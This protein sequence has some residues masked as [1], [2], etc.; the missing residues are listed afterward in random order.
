MKYQNQ[1]ILL[2]HLKKGEEK[3]Y[4]YLV[5]TYNKRLFGYALTL[6]RNEEIAQDIIQ[7]VFL[8]TWE[9]R[10]KIHITSS[11]QNYLFRSVHNEFITLYNKKRST[12]LL[13]QKY[14]ESL[15]RVTKG[16]D[17]DFL[18]KALERITIEIENLPFKCK[19][20]FLLSRKEGLTNIEIADYLNI[21]IKTVEAHITKAF[22]VLRKNLKDKLN[23]ILFI[24]FGFQ[25]T[26]KIY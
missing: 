18:I 25:K 1:S 16:Y 10:K 11:L 20:V 8:K 3:A 5:D 15:E 21:S 9:K 22:T 26:Q 14:F 2:K 24:L 7:N 6:C 17:E 23:T 19:R 13:E 12:I 4:I